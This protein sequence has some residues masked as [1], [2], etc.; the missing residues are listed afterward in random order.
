MKE[1]GM[2]THTILL[3]VVSISTFPMLAA[4]WSISCQSNRI[5]LDLLCKHDQSEPGGNLAL[6]Q[7]LERSR[8][9][10]SFGWIFLLLVWGAVQYFVDD[11]KTTMDWVFTLTFALSYVACVL[12]AGHYQDED[13][14]NSVGLGQRAKLRYST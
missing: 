13:L 14:L 11:T 2:D 9:A 6:W 10:I 7:K 8:A 3:M 5:H 1:K 4:Y 12:M